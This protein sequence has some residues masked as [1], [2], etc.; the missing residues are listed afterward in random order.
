MKKLDPILKQLLHEGTVIP[1]HPLA[2]HED[3]S[4]DEEGQR[5]LSRYYMASGAGGI[6]V[7]VHST[8]FEIRDPKINLFET[9][10]QWAAEEVQKANLDRPFIKVAGICG[11]TEQAVR[12]AETA[13]R[14]NYDIGLLSM[15]GLQD[16]TEEQIL[17]RVRKVAEIMPVFGFYLQPSVGGRIFS[18]A[19]WQAFVE[20]DNVEAIK[21]AS[22]NRYQTLDVMRAL[23]NS[24]RRNDIAMYTGNDDNIIADL[25]STYRFPVNGESV[26]I[27]FK[28]GLLGHWAVWTQKAVDLMQ[29]IKEY[30]KHKT[31]EK[32]DDLLS[33]N[34]EVTDANAA[35]FDPAHHFHGCIPGI[36]EVLRRQGLMKGIW[37]LNPN[38]KLSP[39]QKEE[40][41]RIYIEYP[42]LNDDV[43]VQEFLKKN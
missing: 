29:K 27:N 38:E 11:P 4:I 36:H 10:L 35:F 19:F 12:E 13:V 40:I 3:R 8:Q 32:A 31:N 16:W 17:E 25:L 9:V 20:I 33:R 28:G 43:F 24:S 18:Y 21:C 6:A 37:C 34:I 23:A 14:Y 1:A 30:R 22:F 7:A 42:H 39:G 15:G 2:L 5:L 41:D 26:E